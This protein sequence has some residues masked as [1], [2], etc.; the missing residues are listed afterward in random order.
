[1][2][3]NELFATIHSELYTAVISDVLDAH[4]LR[5]QT[6]RADIR[7]MVSSRK[8]VGRAFTVK[9]IEAY[10]VPEK[11]YQKLIEALDQIGPGEVFVTNTL[12]DRAAFW[13]ELLSTAC[14]ARG[15]TGA[16][17]D[18]LVR[19]LERTEP[20]G[21]SVFGRGPRPVDSMGRFEVLDYRVPLECGG[22][23]VAPGDLVVADPD[24]VVVIP[25][26]VED[27]VIAQALDKVHGEH[28]VREGILH[29][30]SLRELYDRYGV[31]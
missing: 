17:I 11:P 5:N 14:H 12:S 19:D 2:P 27:T 1:M 24:G 25:Q 15:A 29:G 13:G 28:A 7:P 20:I 3:D 4:G 9:V 23:P 31:L 8:V 30:S 22:V 21:F 6:L 18:G 10:V 16:I 26:A